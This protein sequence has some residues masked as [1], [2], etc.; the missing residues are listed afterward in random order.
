MKKKVRRSSLV[1]AHNAKI[2]KNLDFHFEVTNE[3]ILYSCRWSQFTPSVIYSTII[4]RTLNNPLI[5]HDSYYDRDIVFRG[6]LLKQ[7]G[8]LS[9]MWHERYFILRRDNASLCWYQAS[10]PRT[11]MVILGGFDLTQGSSLK[12]E[13]IDNH[14]ITFSTDNLQLTVRCKD[15][16]ER[17]AWLMAI[18]SVIRTG[19]SSSTPWWLSFFGDDERKIA[20]K[21]KLKNKIIIPTLDTFP[22]KSDNVI[23]S[24]SYLKQY[25][26]SKTQASGFQLG[27]ILQQQVCSHFE[28]ANICAI[29]LRSQLQDN[30]NDIKWKEVMRT[31]VRKLDAPS[32]IIDVHHTYFSI[33]LSEKNLETEYKKKKKHSKEYAMIIL[34]AE[35]SS[36]MEPIARS[37][38]PLLDFNG[39]LDEN[40]VV[41]DPSLDIQCYDMEMIFNPAETIFSVIGMDMSIVDNISSESIILAISKVNCSDLYNTIPDLADKLDYMIT[42]SSSESV[43]GEPYATS[44]FSFASEFGRTVCVEHLYASRMNALAAVAFLE[45]RILR[46]LPESEKKGDVMKVLIDAYNEALR[47]IADDGIENLQEGDCGTCLRPSK[48]K[49]EWQVQ[50]LTINLNLQVSYCKFENATASTNESISVTDAPISKRT[51][52]DTLVTEINEIDPID[53]NTLVFP[54]LTLGCPTVHAYGFKDGGLGSYFINNCNLDKSDVNSRLF[55]IAKLQ[56]HGINLLEKE[57]SNEN[58]GVRL[59]LVCS[60]TLG[61]ALT[62]AKSSIALATA[63][64]SRQ[65]NIF[66]ESL[67]NVLK[68]GLLVSVCSLLSSS[69]NEARMLEDLE[70]GLHWLSIVQL[71]LVEDDSNKSKKKVS[72]SRINDDLLRIRMIISK[73]EAIIVKKA[74]ASLL[75][76]L[77]KNE[78]HHQGDSDDEFDGN[79]KDIGSGIVAMIQMHGFV[80]TQGVNEKQTIATTAML[81]ER[82]TQHRINNESLNRFE[83]YYNNYQEFR[84]KA[85]NKSLMR[86]KSVNKS[87]ELIIKLREAIYNN[88]NHKSMNV[89]MVASAL[90]REMGSIPSFMCK[91]GK[92]RTAQAVT[93]AQTQYVALKHAVSDSQ[94]VLDVF[95]RYGV[96]RHNVYA[97]TGQTQFAFT[98]FQQVF[99]PQ[100]L[101]PPL[102]TLSTAIGSHVET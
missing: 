84:T 1:E 51:S 86:K 43:V 31:E 10:E 66:F 81:S 15:D 65:G 97:N 50:G 101:R 69:Q 29:V 2:N 100:C 49:K 64:S 76:I 18:T 9:S 21:Y 4:R 72:I 26:T 98:S 14:G 85:E 63:H 79:S 61:H 11:E 95:R 60:Q 91:S 47:R 19:I 25:I 37:I 68:N 89:L 78:H 99:L 41:F 5:R 102:E 40:G 73:D 52:K 93:L 6:M 28:D 88:G 58:V 33:L 62:A 24:P 48:M 67:Q 55:E 34:C 71:E 74:K 38:I 56:V 16:S 8:I 77:D 32:I 94:H 92:D 46:D 96:R 75:E 22:K 83:L 57:H 27:F 7:R 44:L 13:K 80:F 35:H 59:D 53:E 87:D 20:N 82:E 42:S 36:S 54:C 45:F 30:G 12:I 3:G 39:S 23:K 70:V 17:I 90:L